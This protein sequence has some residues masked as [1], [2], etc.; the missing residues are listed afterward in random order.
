MSRFLSVR[1]KPET[2]ED[3]R[4][5]EYNMIGGHE[6]SLDLVSHDFCCGRIHS[7]S[8]GPLVQK[9]LSRAQASRSHHETPRAEPASSLL[10][11]TQANLVPSNNWKARHFGTLTSFYKTSIQAIQGHGILI[12]SKTEHIYK[13]LVRKQA[14]PLYLRWDVDTPS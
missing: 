6:L 1:I 5:G 11:G 9:R 4:S 12:H 2:N 14:Q 13:H 8:A 3:T 10:H 7:C